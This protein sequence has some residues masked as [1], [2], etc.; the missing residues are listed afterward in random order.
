M[1]HRVN[2]FAVSLLQLLHLGGI[3]DDRHQI[4]HMERAHFD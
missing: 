3:V 4:T 2:P 1:H